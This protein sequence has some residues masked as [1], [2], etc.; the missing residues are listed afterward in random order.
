MER[1]TRE[2]FEKLRNFLNVEEESRMEAL[3]T[4]TERKTGEMRQRIEEIETNISSVSETLRVLE[5]EM[6]LEDISVLHV[7][8]I[9]LKM[10]IIKH[11]F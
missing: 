2:E 10:S 9:K 4:E 6:A 3:R 8:S 7:C 5:E 1:R 11:N